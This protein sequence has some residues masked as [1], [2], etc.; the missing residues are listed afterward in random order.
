M[1]A[2]SRVRGEENN[3]EAEMRY[4]AYRN[5]LKENGIAVDPNLVALGTFAGPTGMAAVIELLDVRKAVFDCL[6]AANDDMPL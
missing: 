1:M 6:V 4:L 3:P 2:S 5:A